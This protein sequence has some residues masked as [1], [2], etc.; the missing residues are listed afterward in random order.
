M[1][2]RGRILVT[3]GG[4]YVGS[5]L[6]PHLLKL[7]HSVRVLDLF[8][9]GDGVFE[10]CRE[11]RGLELVRGDIRDAERVRQAVRGVDAVVHLACISNDPSFELDPALGKSI[12]LDAFPGLVE[13]SLEAGVRRFVYA[14]SSSVYGVKDEPSV[15]EE[16]SP[17]PLT[18]YSR[19]KL[20]CEGL[21]LEACRGEAMV[22][23]VARPATVCGAAPRQRLDLTV[24]ILTAHALERGVIRVFGGSQLRPN[25]HIRDMVAAYQTLLEAPA[26]KVRG[27]AFNIGYENRAVG[28]IAGKVQAALAGD[29]G[30]GAEVEIR[31]EP[32]D[33]LRSYHI[34][35]GK[36]LR[37]LGF[38]PRRTLE[39][40]ILELAEA[41]AAGLLVDP[42]ENP[43]YHNI[44][45]MR[46]LLRSP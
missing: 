28:E 29:A 5:A 42:L 24:N 34:D 41:H 44:R 27:E 4:G 33:D 26:A 18:D 1:S 6:V 43:I 7:G 46:Q 22:P 31:V 35:S 23:I 10:A 2:A 17:E 3:G 45:R 13:A 39:D 8:W 16:A 12:N 9:Y 32:S 25:L 15:R 20:E 40:A 30:G 21:L 14:S 19:F 36:I 37:V 11:D 38:R